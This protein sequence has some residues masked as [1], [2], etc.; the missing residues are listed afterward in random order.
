MS[1]LNSILLGRGKV[2]KKD[3]VGLS[4]RHSFSDYLP[5]ITYRETKRD[6]DEEF[7]CDEFLLKDATYGYMW[8]CNPL[9]FVGGRQLDALHGLLKHHYP[10]DSVLQFLFY[11]D[12]DLEPWLDSYADGKNTNDPVCAAS[13]K[14]TS[15][16]F[17]GGTK[18]LPALFGVPLRNFRLFICL[19]SPNSLNPNM[20][21]G[22]NQSMVS[23]GLSP[24]PMD[25]GEL[26]SFLYKFI[27]NKTHKDI[28]VNPH[29]PI[30][31]QVINAE[32]KIRVEPG[33][34]YMKV[35]DRYA[36]CLTP[37]VIPQGNDPLKTNALFGGYMGSVDNQNQITTPFL[38]SFTIVF[39][40]A[41]TLLQAKAATVNWQRKAKKVSFKLGE[42]VKEFDAAGK[43]LAQGGK[44]VYYIPSLWIFGDSRK[45]LNTGINDVKNIWGSQDY[46]MQTESKMRS[47]MFLQ[48]MPFG[49]Y[50]VDGNLEK[51]NRY[52]LANLEDVARLLPVQGDFKGTSKPVV[53]YVG[54][55]GQ[56]IGI[57]FFDP[58]AVAHNFLVAGLTGG[59]KSFL[60]NDMVNA[61]LDSGCKIRITDIGGSYEKTTLTRGG[62]YIDFTVRNSP[63]INPIDYVSLDIE[64]AAKNMDAAVTVL[65]EMTYSFTGKAASETEATLL[66]DAVR[67]VRE[68]GYQEG[69]I[70]PVRDF[71]SNYNTLGYELKDDPKICEMAKYMAFNMKAFGSKGDYGK[72]FNG[73]ST[74][75]ISDEQ[76]V[77]IE[78]EQIRAVRELFG[79]VVM[80]TMNNVTQDLYLGDRSVPTLVL[81]EEV[82]SFL[83]KIGHTD[84]SRLGDMIEEGYRR[85][86]KYYGAFGVVLQSM[87]DLKMF[88][89]VGDVI[90]TNAIFKY[91]LESPVFREAVDEG[92]IPNMK[93]FAVDLL[94]SMVSAKPRYSEFFIDAGSLGRGVARLSVDPYRYNV[95]NSEGVE[96]S[97]FKALLNAGFKPDK[98]LE[99]MMNK[100]SVFNYLL[101]QG[102][103]SIEAAEIAFRKQI[104]GEV[105]AA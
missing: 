81:Y 66:K 97:K 99:I 79:V 92:C 19:K 68:S 9:T 105:I 34:E 37:K 55:K 16:F 10:K 64:D 48:A 32:T 93:G 57:N 31:K 89:G 80:Q 71:L 54:R 39:R 18:G 82:A 24:Q 50:N 63:C 8:E 88:G 94:E 45:H 51:L 100:G 13:L 17:R 2:D 98:C 27:N 61:Y 67:W 46:E 35:G 15:D 44:Y 5:Y 41:K 49:F 14:S 78:L 52:F 12:H 11:S 104:Q 36:A 73:K 70:D 90:K 74:L 28:P 85:A 83:K 75:N 30:S 87:L 4:H 77:C 26:L 6:D 72:L 101:N 29:Q 20:L 22:V 21:E 33:K 1:I 60:I 47:A 62:R 102:V 40:N 53:T 3:I 42:L 23:A 59:G 69:G 91:Y 86:R 65:S 43:S 25:D 58:R 103:G 56:V 96:I 95:N 76:A 38:Y 7:K 84:M